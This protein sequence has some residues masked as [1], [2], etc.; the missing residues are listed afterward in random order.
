MAKWPVQLPRGPGNRGSHVEEK[1]RVFR[2]PRCDTLIREERDFGSYTE[3]TIEGLRLRQQAPSPELGGLGV[4][5]KLEEV[6][7]EGVCVYGELH[8]R[9]PRTSS[10]QA[11]RR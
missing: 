2:L 8:S 3:S 5:E 10:R 11:S 9:T 6:Q 4:C 1:G 7:R